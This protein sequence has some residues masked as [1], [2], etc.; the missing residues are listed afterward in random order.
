[1]TLQNCG[2]LDSFQKSWYNNKGSYLALFGIAYSYQDDNP[3][4]AVSF[5]KQ[6][7]EQAPKCDKQYDDAYY[8][9]AIIE[10]I[11][12]ENLDAALRY[13]ALGDDIYAKR[14]PFLEKYETP[15]KH[16]MDTVRIMLKLSSKH[17]L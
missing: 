1:M 4:K 14:L 13:A 3:E 5:F 17:I 9:L 8:N 2:A 16:M 6:Y 10:L 11:N 12:Y 7:I 15:S